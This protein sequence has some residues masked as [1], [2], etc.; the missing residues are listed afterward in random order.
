MAASKA[1]GEKNWEMVRVSDSFHP[2]TTVVV[3]PDPKLVQSESEP[4]PN[5]AIKYY[6]WIDNFFYKLTVFFQYVFVSYQS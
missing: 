4:P 5:P 6:N 2:P 3:A 1:A